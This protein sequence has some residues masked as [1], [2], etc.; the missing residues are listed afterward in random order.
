M[1]QSLP[2]A[3][4]TALPMQAPDAVSGTTRQPLVALLTGGADKPYA[5][6]LSTALAS[7]GISLDF[8]GSDEINGPELH[9]NPFIRFLNLRGAQHVDASTLQKFLRVVRYYVRLVAYAIRSQAPIF[10]ILWN[11]KFEHFDRTLLMLYYKMLGKKIT[12]TAH[13]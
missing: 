3:S 7:A 8:I 4:Q 10:H 12:F 1:V 6:G 11:N 9:Y 5:L 2:T 13:N